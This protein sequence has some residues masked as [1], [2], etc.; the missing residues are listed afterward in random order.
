MPPQD[1]DPF[2]P[3]LARQAGLL[4]VEEQDKLAGARVAVLGLGGVGG[5][6]AE[7]LARAGV[8]SL[9]VCD[10]DVFEA[11][12]LNR[13]VGALHS[14]LGCAKAEVTAERLLDINPGLELTV[15]GPV[16]SMADAE[17]VL[18]GNAAG[19]LA[20]DQLGPSLLALRA[21]RS[22]EVPLV[23]AL[24]LPVI[25]VRVYSPDGPDPEEG[26]PSQGLAADELERA[27]LASAYGAM[28]PG[29]W[30]DG[31]GGPFTLDARVALAMAEH[32]GAASLGPLVWLAG[33][34]AALEVMKLIVGRGRLA[35]HPAGVSFDPAAW[36]MHFE[37]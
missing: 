8:G 13:Q 37:E 6:A 5:V 9:A 28:E 29:R 17:R 2:G 31:D 24:A 20:I 30:R 19:V 22:L 36:R 12:N 3:A 10:G 4:S 15:A 34:L 14:S 35:V 23:E 26:R 21:A 25:Q 11:S 16:Q 27:D 33:S 7:L 1:H 18:A 32:H